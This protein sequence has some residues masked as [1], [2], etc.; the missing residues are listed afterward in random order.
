MLTTKSSL[1]VPNPI[2]VQPHHLYQSKLAPTIL[3]L[4]FFTHFTWLFPR[5]TLSAGHTGGVRLK[6]SW[7]NPAWA[8]VLWHQVNLARIKF[9]FVFF[10]LFLHQAEGKEDESYDDAMNVVPKTLQSL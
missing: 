6:E 7:K 2:L 9:L 5:R 3:S 8:P 10:F 1:C 4:P